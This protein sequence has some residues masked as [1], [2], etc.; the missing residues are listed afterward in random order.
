MGRTSIADLSAGP[1]ERR[2]GMVRIPGLEPAWE[3]PAVVVRGNTP[4]PTFAVTS[5]MHAAEYVPIEAVTRLTRWLDPTQLRGTVVAVLLVNTPGFYERSIYVNPRDGRNLNRSFP[6]DA[7]GSPAERV[8]AFLLE[9]L[10]AGSDAYVDAHCGDLIEALSPFTLWTRAGD[11][12][13]AAKSRDMAAVY[14]FAHTLGVDPES[15]PGAAYASAALRG[16]PAIIAEI[17]QQGICD[18]PSVEGHLR[19]LQNVMAHLGMIPA[20]GGPVATPVPMDRM[21]WMRTDIS[22]TYHPTVQVGDRVA[23]GQV[24]GELRDIF[25]DTLREVRTEAGGFVVFLVTSLAVKA[26]DPL[27]GVGVPEA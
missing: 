27:L 15:V 7:N 20:M 25:G 3:I 19:G 26:G 13:V 10:I 18:E 2:R 22:A 24:V 8:A 12:A 5:G 11:P 16:V 9:E 14:G 21:V 1:G 23:E 17:G 4:G 6:G